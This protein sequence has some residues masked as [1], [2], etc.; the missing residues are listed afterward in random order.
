MPVRQQIGRS[1]ER[2]AAIHTSVASDLNQPI[3]L[4]SYEHFMA[5]LLILLV[6]FRTRSW[7]GNLDVRNK[8]KRLQY[9]I[10]NIC[11]KYIY[12]YLQ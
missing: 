1:A 9:L 12:I 11:K 7:D 2:I 3:A 8:E 6:Y 5:I 4:S 10:F